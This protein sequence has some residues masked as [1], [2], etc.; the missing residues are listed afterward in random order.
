MKLD[1]R[2]AAPKLPSWVWGHDPE[3]YA[4][5][6]YANIVDGMKKGIRLEDDER[7]P[8]NYPPGY[9]Y[10]PWNIE[11]IMDDMRAGKPFDLG[12]GNWD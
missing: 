10:E 3:L 9:R 6:N 4:Y 11:Q 12:P 1:P 7:V 5:Q 2:R 8:P